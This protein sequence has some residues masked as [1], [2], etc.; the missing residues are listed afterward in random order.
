MIRVLICDDQPVVR[1]G[2][3][4][5]LRPE[6]GIEVVGE[7][8]DGFGAVEAVE[9]LSP[10]VVLMDI[11]MPGR[12]GIAATELIRD[13]RADAHVLILTNFDDDDLVREALLS[14]AA[15]F[16]LKD[17]PPEQ[18][19]EAVRAVARGEAMLTPTV[20]RSLIDAFT[21]QSHTPIALPGADQLSAREREVWRL[22]A[23]GLSNGEIAEHLVLGESTVKTHVRRILGKLGAR[24]RV[25]LV[26]MAFAAGLI[27]PGEN[28]PEG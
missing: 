18:I 25:Q 11:R 14:G 27:H 1:A 3:R 28:H 9:R 6:P 4:L 8:E 13:A 17:A 21:E 5:V 15:G 23:L 7:A 26:V 2:L 22:I 20:T 12:D 16:I 19:V 10:D 24:D